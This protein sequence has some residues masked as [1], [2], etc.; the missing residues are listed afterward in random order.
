MPLCDEEE[1]RYPSSTDLNHCRSVA[2]L[3]VD[4]NKTR[5][6]S[7][8]AR[9]GDALALRACS[10]IVLPYG[11]TP[12]KRRAQ[13]L[14]SRQVGMNFR[15]RTCRRRSSLEGTNRATSPTCAQPGVQAYTDDGS[16]S[17]ANNEVTEPNEAKAELTSR[18]PELDDDAELEKVKRRY[19]QWL[20]TTSPELSNEEIL[21]EVA[22]AAD[23]TPQPIE[24]DPV[25]GADEEA[26]DALMQLVEPGQ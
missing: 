17:C 6:L 9:L 19:E 16:A 12:L 25:T 21:A 13:S 1:R 2:T 24:D 11:Q 10:K 14:L 22:E 3:F 15:W 26:L 4:T 20:R 7:A 18:Q 8:P 23:V 5:S